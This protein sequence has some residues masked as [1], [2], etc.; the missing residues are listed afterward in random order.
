MA[1]NN[2]YQTQVWLNNNLFA[3]L[4]GIAKNHSMSITR[5]R[6]DEI[7]FDLDLD[8]FT[9]YALSMKLQAQDILQT[10]AAEVR[11]LK[12][13]TTISAGQLFDYQAD[14]QG[15]QRTVSAHAVGWL[16][17][18]KYRLTNNTYT[19]QSAAFIARDIISTSLSQSYGNFGVVLGAIPSPDNTNV[20]PSKVYNEKSIYDAIVEMSDELGGYD[21]QFT[22]DKH[23]DIFSSIGTQRKDIVFTYPGN[24]Q[25]I[26]ITKDSSKMVNSL[27]SRGMGFGANQQ[28]VNVQDIGS[29]NAYF[30]REGIKDFS[31]I[32]DVTQL[33]NLAQGELKIYKNPLTIHE[34]TYDPSQ[35]GTPAVGSYHIGD[36]VQL[37]VKT[38]PLYSDVNQYFRIDKIHIK[39]SE[40]GVETVSLSLAS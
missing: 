29:Q 22:W 15:D 23:F 14:L 24:I 2:K 20:Y 37:N 9:Q 32:Q 34:V 8:Q 4:T 6:A 36:Q 35:S 5:N 27:F 17:L 21:F 10:G 18:F 16:E 25:E 7:S 11:V 30:L 28:A 38:L 1:F 40:D 26:K 31:D 3:D 39:I 19:S 33:T 13:G 12:Q